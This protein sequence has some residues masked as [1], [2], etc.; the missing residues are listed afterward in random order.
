[1]HG[2]GDESDSGLRNNAKLLLLIW[3]TF[4]WQS[5]GPTKEIL[6]VTVHV[7]ATCITANTA[8]IITHY[9]TKLLPI[10][11]QQLAI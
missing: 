9:T 5:S 4:E 1:M 6:R 11:T 3:I 8:A 7:Y 10:E 2:E